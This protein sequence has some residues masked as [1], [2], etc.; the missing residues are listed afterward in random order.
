[1]WQNSAGEQMVEMCHQTA[2]PLI[3]PHINEKETIRTIKGTLCRTLV[4]WWFPFTGI[5]FY[6]SFKFIKCWYKCF[7][8][9]A[10]PRDEFKGIPSFHQGLYDWTTLDFLCE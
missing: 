6:C 2:R 9:L 4:E 7:S 10:F 5:T 3:W 1:M 8:C